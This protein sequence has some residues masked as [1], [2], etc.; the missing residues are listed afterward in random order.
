MSNPINP[1]HYKTGGIECWDAMEQVYGIQETMIF[2]KLN[3]F[4]YL[5]R[6]DRKNGSE[7][8]QKA[9][10]YLEKYLELNNKLDNKGE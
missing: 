8:I 5:W 7:D 6:C 2:C 3:A 9:K 4:K 10:V 1:N